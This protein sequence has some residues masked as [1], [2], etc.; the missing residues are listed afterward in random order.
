[1]LSLF[2]SFFC[3]WNKNDHMLDM[4]SLIKCFLF[5]FLF[6]FDFIISYTLFFLVKYLIYF[7]DTKEQKNE[8][9]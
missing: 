5:F 4:I 2:F 3:F 9:I 7:M 1:M 8:Y 6:L